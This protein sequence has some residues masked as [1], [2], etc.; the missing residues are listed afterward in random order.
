[1]LQNITNAKLVGREEDVMPT[2]NQCAEVGDM[3]PAQR[4]VSY[5]EKSNAVQFTA[6]S[7]SIL[8]KGYGM[9]RNSLMVE[10]TLKNI[11][12]K[13][14]S[15]DII[16]FNTAMDAYIR[17]GNPKKA[18]Q[19]FYAL[20]DPGSSTSDNSDWTT[21]IGP[22]LRARLRP[23]IRTFNTLLKSLQEG[24]QPNDL[25]EARKVLVMM[26]AV[27]VTP[28]SI[29]F[30]TVI[31][32]CVRANDLIAA[33]N[34][35]RD[36]MS[37]DIWAHTSLLSG[38]ASKGKADD[39]VRILNLMTNRGLVP[40]SHTLSA[41]MTAFVK[42]NDLDLAKK[43]LADV[44]KG[45][46]PGVSK[47]QRA[48]LHGTYIASLCRLDSEASISSAAMALSN[49]ES[50]GVLPSTFV[51]NVVIKGLCSYGRIL[52][53]LDRMRTMLA[54]GPEPDKFTYSIIFSY[55]GRNGNLEEALE[56]YRT[57]KL[58][59]D[60]PA[61]N[62]LLR[63]FVGG[64][65][66]DPLQAVKLFDE[67]VS[68]NHS[69]GDV[70]Y[71]VPSQVTYT[72]LFL[73]L[74]HAV[75]PERFAGRARTSWKT[76][77]TPPLPT[78]LPAEPTS[79]LPSRVLVLDNDT[80][81]LY[82]TTAGP[83][84]ALSSGKLSAGQVDDTLLLSLVPSTGIEVED[85]LLWVESSRSPIR[86]QEASKEALI[87]ASIDQ[88]F[89]RLFRAM[90]FEY[91][92]PVDEVALSA[93]NTLFSLQPPTFFPSGAFNFD[94]VLLPRPAAVLS[95]KTAKMVF[96]DLLL[97]GY[98]PQQMEPIF[99]SCGFS[100]WTA[101]SYRDKY[102]VCGS[103]ATGLATDAGQRPTKASYRIFNRYGWNKMDSGWNIL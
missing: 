83:N 48:V 82:E 85:K 51:Y 1:M 40:N 41:L 79:S 75:D 102:S 18:S 91:N 89:S 92:L 87:V 70:E 6:K 27:G 50:T 35:L 93:L 33:E 73:S 7:Y 30:N 15:V 45:V 2:L 25:T 22:F 71:F 76:T 72:I 39:A 63:A 37:A 57:S 46:I 47:E 19:L 61:M 49:L 65:G 26:R 58:Q 28:D 13:R 95:P 68:H 100:S 43:L 8:L 16:L 36:S 29:S 88:I 67:L 101:A 34:L 86:V 98:L 60:T 96:E 66:T 84:T 53:A 24:G 44:D 94:S 21:L 4:I 3:R 9:Q 11:V 103:N 59:L 78:P 62:A 90:R 56:L 99:Q 42:G 77:P 17:C 12:T 14:I 5:L 64:T 31:D 54:V 32:T 69:T 97:L 10:S 52:E 80:S 55:L 81:R 74:A 23:N 20:Q 38:Y